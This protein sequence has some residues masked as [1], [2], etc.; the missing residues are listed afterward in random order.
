MRA[1]NEPMMPDFSGDISQ[2]FTC[3]GESAAFVGA[4]VG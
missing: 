2:E 4:W 3:L 1:T